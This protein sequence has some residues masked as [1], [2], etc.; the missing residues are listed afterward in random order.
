MKEVEPNSIYW[1]PSNDELKIEST[2]NNGII[3]RGKLSKDGMLRSNLPVILSAHL[4]KVYTSLHE[5]DFRVLDPRSFSQTDDFIAYAEDEVQRTKPVN[6][7]WWLLI[8]PMFFLE[9]FV[10]FNSP[11][12]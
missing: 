7:S 3:I 5:H 8:L 2:I 6:S 12:S 4:N 9:R 1:I 10:Y 11:T